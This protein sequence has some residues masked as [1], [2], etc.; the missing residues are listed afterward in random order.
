MSADDEFHFRPRPGRVRS[1]VPKAGKAKSFLT[2]AKK[3]ARQQS[4][5]PSRSSALSSSRSRS[6]SPGNG[7]KASRTSAPGLSQSRLAGS[8]ANV[9]R[10]PALEPGADLLWVFAGLGFPIH[11]ARMLARGP[12]CVVGVKLLF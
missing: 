1:D 2:Q 12:A 9:S 8:Q 6:S 7:G 11:Q 4:N 3:I 5:S 10:W